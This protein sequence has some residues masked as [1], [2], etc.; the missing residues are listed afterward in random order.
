MGDLILT[1]DVGTTGNK[2]TIFNS[3]GETLASNTVAYDT[4]YP[5][6]G[7]SQQNADDYW[8]SVV[9]GT[10]HLV[11]EFPELAADICCIGLSGHMNGMLPVDREGNALIPEII[12]SDN[13][14][15]GFCDF[16]RKEIGDDEFFEIT[17]NRIDSHLSLPKMLWF[18]ENHPDL[19][20][21]TAWFLQSKDYIAGRLTG[22]FG[23][24]D[25]SDASLTCVLDLRKKSWSGP[26]S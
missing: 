11:R 19:Y 10:N 20:K 21:K 25:L 2:C 9:R 8:D 26:Y 16:I 6:S 15:A 12:H 18:R 3:S 14:S 4:E 1:Y 24:T 17:G 13:R 7:W 22:S 23:K 5:R